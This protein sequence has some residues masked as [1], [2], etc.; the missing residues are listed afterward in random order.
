MPVEPNKR[1]ASGLLVS[2]EC[3]SKYM[4]IS[5]SFSFSA[6]FPPYHLHSALPGTMC[7]VSQSTPR[8]GQASP[9]TSAPECCDQISQRF[10]SARPAQSTKYVHHAPRLQRTLR[11]AT[12]VKTRRSKQRTTRKRTQ[13]QLTLRITGAGSKRRRPTPQYELPF[14][15][16]L[17]TKVCG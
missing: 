9:G 6:D 12:K 3:S 2:S 10:G 4:I 13:H 1:H 14:R 17:H 8:F 5:D 11:R 15:V 7:V 16:E